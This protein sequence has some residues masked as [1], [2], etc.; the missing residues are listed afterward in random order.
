MQPKNSL[1]GFFFDVK[2]AMVWSL[3]IEMWIIDNR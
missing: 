2:S 3:Y 1:T